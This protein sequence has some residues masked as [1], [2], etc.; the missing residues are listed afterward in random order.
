M[1]L[2]KYTVETL[3]SW[4]NLGALSIN[5]LLIYIFFFVLNFSVYIHTFALVCPNL[6]MAHI[7]FMNGLYVNFNFKLKVK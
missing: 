4:E 1:H 3:Y 2:I 6:E 7:L 5:N